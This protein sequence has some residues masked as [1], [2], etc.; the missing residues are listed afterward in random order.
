MACGTLLRTRVRISPPPP[1]GRSPA[2]RLRPHGLNAGSAICDSA[3]NGVK[4]APER[5]WDLAR[6]EGEAVQDLLERRIVGGAGRLFDLEGVA[7]ALDDHDDRP[8]GR[9]RIDDLDP[10]GLD[11]RH[12]G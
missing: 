10:I 2:C 8:V 12:R 11:R 7:L 3:R 5:S 4:K 1:A 9:T 6:G